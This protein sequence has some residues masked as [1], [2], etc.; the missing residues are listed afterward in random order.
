[1]WINKLFDEEGTIGRV[2]SFAITTLIVLSIIAFCLETLPELS[3]WERSALTVFEVVVV[4][5]FSAEYLLRLFLAEKKLRFIFSFFGMIDLIAILPFFLGGLDLRAS[6]IFRVMRVLRMFKI[7]RYSVALQRLYKAFMSIR[8][9]LLL[10][11]VATSFVLFLSAVGIYQF[12]HEAQPEVFRSIF[13]SLW[14]AV[15]TLTT[16]GYGDAYPI[17]LGGRMFTF[18]ILMVGLG[19]IAVPS[20]LVASALTRTMDEAEEL[21]EAAKKGRDRQ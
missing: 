19:V 21:E 7:I 6:R 17:T 2:F 8:E 18:I 1:M 13:D 3:E 14:W 16:V 15:V 20:G 5:I 11:L 12:E 4:I 9:E 10:F